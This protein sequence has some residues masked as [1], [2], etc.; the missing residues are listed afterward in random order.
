M[1]RS[2]VP[3]L[4]L[5][6]I[7]LA[8]LLFMCVMT[9]VT[10][11]EDLY[12]SLR[13]M[14]KLSPYLGKDPDAFD[15]LNARIRSFENEFSTGLYGT[16]ALQNTNARVQYAAGKQM[17]NMG[18]ANMVRL[19]SGQLY[20]ITEKLDMEPRADLVA[21]FCDMVKDKYAV[22]V[23]VLYE[24]PSLYRNDQLPAGYEALDH[25]NEN[26]DS[27][28]AR[29]ASREIDL[30]DSRD[31]LPCDDESLSR[32]IYATDQHWTCLAQLTLARDLA[33][34]LGLDASLLDTDKFECESHPAAFLG[35]YGQRIGPEAAPPD[36]IDI[37]LPTYD[38]FITRYTLMNDIPQQAEGTFSEAAVRRGE[39]EHDEGCDYSTMGYR[40]L[41]L[42]EDL[43]I[44]TNPTAPD[45]T[46]LLF[47]DS[48]SAGI[49]AYLSLTARNV[50][51]VDLRKGART[52][53][54]WIREY[55]PDR[56]VIAFSPRMLTESDYSL[57]D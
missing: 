20:D 27:Y 5:T 19:T 29:L 38:T 45:V 12:N 8:G 34:H 54:D 32:L 50:I 44:Y 36:D 16:Q 6:V 4:V 15:M 48:Y 21:D 10:D 9:F 18:S 42:T 37:W 3:A 40:V 13:Y 39:L 26:A 56:V 51:S 11:G 2:S 33:E 22:P 23:T 52:A 17:L 46:V 14:T 31:L 1:K 43:D 35:K 7:F 47:K 41:G 55:S 49:G 53:G 30:M 24:H 25:L 57:T 28:T